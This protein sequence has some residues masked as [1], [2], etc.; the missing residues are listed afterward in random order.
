[1]FHPEFARFWIYELAVLCYCA[2][3]VLIP[4]LVVH[5]EKKRIGRQ[6]L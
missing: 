3:A 5:K 6:L 4:W 2:L 1:M